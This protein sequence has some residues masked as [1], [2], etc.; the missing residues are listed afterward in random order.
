MVD[1]DRG[2]LAGGVR[3]GFAKRRC[4]QYVCISPPSIASWRSIRDP[5]ILEG[6]MTRVG[7]DKR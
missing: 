6:V 1:M 7:H 2:R 5:H 3:S 4:G